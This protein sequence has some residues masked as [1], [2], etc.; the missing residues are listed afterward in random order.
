MAEGQS[1]EAAL[2]EWWAKW[3]NEDF[4]WTGLSDKPLQ[5]WSVI[6]RADGG[7]WL[8]ET[9]SGALYG[10]GVPVA[11][12]DAPAEAPSHGRYATLQ[13]Y[14]RADPNTGRLRTEDELIDAG[15]L[16]L[17]PKLFPPPH[18]GEHKVD[19]TYHIA[20]LP[21]AYADGT[22]TA[23][24]DWKSDALDAIVTARLKAAKEMLGG[25]DHRAQF[26]GGVWLRAPRP[27]PG[28]DG[29]IPFSVDYTGAFFQG[30]ASFDDADFQGDADFWDAA[31]H[32]DASFNGADFQGDALFHHAKFHGDADFNNA[33]FH[34]DAIFLDA[35]FRGD[36]GF[37]NALFRHFV[38]FAET[39]FEKGVFFGNALFEGVATF[40]PKN[41][42]KEARHWHRAFKNTRFAA[43]PNFESDQFGFF[44]RFDGALFERCVLLPPGSEKEGKRILLAERA[45][46]LKAANA[47]Y[48]DWLGEETKEAEKNNTPSPTPKARADKRTAFRNTRLRELAGGCRVLK[49]AMAFASDPQREQQIYRYELMAQRAQ[50]DLG[51][52]VKTSS[53]LFSLLSDYGASVARPFIALFLTLLVFVALYAGLEHGLALLPIGEE[54][55]V[56]APLTPDAV[57]N[58][59]SFSF[60]RVFPF[61]AFENVSTEWFAAFEE[62]YGGWVLL[63]RILATLQ[64]LIAITLAFL[65]GLAVRRRFQIA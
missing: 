13:D 65:F 17:D 25:V 30:D 14:W 19:E 9:E 40:A 3:R 1:K 15:E 57:V 54:T 5:G 39:K 36:A 4:S 33:A 8:V 24:A 31:F 59:L 26:D 53:L 47:D 6:T 37:Y 44:A 58:T 18:A 21:L 41:W 2:T 56:A 63:A 50:T 64:S 34:G 60:S 10:G 27:I 62:K 29:P 43:T 52:G 51:L 46:A 28:Q 22:P 45:A 55:H 32:L 38:W 7:E 11:P 12:N 42:P 35:A 20:H 16:I 23:K 48:E 61:G 49:Q